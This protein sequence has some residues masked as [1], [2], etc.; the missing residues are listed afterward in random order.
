MN[1]EI[2]EILMS[3]DKMTLDEAEEAL[4]HAR[5][6]VDKGA[7]IEDVLREEFGLEPDYIYDLIEI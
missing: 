2:I 3:R 1:N 7:D 5:R 6:R 4:Q